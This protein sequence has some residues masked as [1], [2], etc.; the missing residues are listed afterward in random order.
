[1]SEAFAKTEDA[2]VAPPRRSAALAQGAR[3]GV[4]ALLV[5]GSLYYPHAPASW[6]ARALHAYVGLVARAA[7]FTIGLFDHSAK[8][9][10]DTIIAGRFPL[11][12]VLDCTA[13]DVQALY[14]AAVLSLAAPVVVKLAGACAGL[15]FL[16]LA[17]L[18]RIAALYFV[19]V[20]APA[21]FDLLH[22]DVMTFAMMACACLAFVTFAQLASARSAGTLAT[23]S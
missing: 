23:R 5:F 12:I 18:A 4:F 20:A 3:F 14:L 6:P 9:L 17:N 7:A 10:D 2:L 21:R 13:L 16:T 22:E 19:G 8:L 1:M 11:Q 15:V